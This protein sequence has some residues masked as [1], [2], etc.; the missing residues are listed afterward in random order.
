MSK[1]AGIFAVIGMLFF[2][3]GNLAE[4]KT[5]QDMEMIH[6]YMNESMAC[7]SHGLPYG[8]SFSDF[9]ILTTSRDN[10]DGL[11]Y[12][13][14]VLF[15]SLLLFSFFKNNKYLHRLYFK[16]IRDRYGSWRFFEKF[17]NLFRFGIINSKI[18]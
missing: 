13:F 5:S 1:L 17:L 4:F 12:F 2:G 3:Y 15:S 6:N 7:C 18:Y 16:K 8:A 14:V 11:N 10:A 9:A